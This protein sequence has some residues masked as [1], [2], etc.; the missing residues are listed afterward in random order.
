[1]ATKTG[2]ASANALTGTTDADVLNGMG[3][4]DTLKGL[5]GNDSLNGGTGN[6]LLDAGT[7]TDTVDGGAGVDTVTFATWS[8]GV[9]LNLSGTYSQYIGQTG[10]VYNYITL[11]NVEN[12]IGGTGA[13][14]LYGSEGA[15]RME[16]RNGNDSILGYGGNDSLYGGAGNDS[17]QGGDG[18]D[19]LYGDAGADTLNGGYGNDQAFG[20]DGDD[21]FVAS[22][23]AD[24]FNGGAGS[25]TISLE[26][27]YEVN[28]SLATGT[29]TFY[30]SDTLRFTGVENL[31]GGWSDDTLTGSTGANVLD[32]AQGNDSLNG[33]AGNDT[34]VGGDGNDTLVGGTGIDT[35][36][37]EAATVGVTVNLGTTA[38]QNTQV[39]T[40][41]L[42]GI[43]NVT[44]S[45][46]NDV[47]TGNAG[48]NLFI[49]GEGN[50]TFNG[51]SG[52]DTVSYVRAGT[53]V[54]VDLAKTTA[55]NTLGEGTDKLASIENLVGSGYDD[56][57]AGN[58][59]ANRLTGGLG[60][61]VL[62]GRGG[63]DTL[64]GGAG[65]DTASYTE[66]TTALN[67]SLASATP[68]AAGSAG[69]DTLISI[70]GLAGGSASDRLTGSAG[71]NRLEG[72]A[73]NDTLLGGD[74][75]DTLEGGAGNDALNGGAGV[76][77]ADYSSATTAVTVDLAK[78]AAQN[79]G[80]AG[81]DTLT[82]IERVIG[83]R[84]GDTLSGRSGS[85][86][87]SGGDG[88][89]KLY[90]RGGSDVLIGG[91][92][93]DVLDAGGG[94]GE[95]MIG[96]AGNDRYF[97]GTGAGSGTVEDSLGSHDVIDAS[98]STTAAQID[99][100]TGKTSTSGG[101]SLTLQV[102]G[103]STLPLD[104]VFVQD[105]SGSFGDDIATVRGLVPNVV[106]AIRGVNG[107][108]AFGV[109]GFVDKPVSP[110][111]GY[112]D[113]VY[114]LF[115]PVSMTTSSVSNAYDSMVI[116]SGSDGPESQLE[117]LF[118]VAK[119]ADGEV[120]FRSDTM[121]VAVLFTDADY[122]VAGDGA[123]AYPD[124]ITRP[125]DGDA[126]IE[127]DGTLE[128]YPSIA[129][130]KGAL[131]AAGIFPFFVVDSYQVDNYKDL[132][133]QLGVGGVTTLADSST[134]VVTAIKNATKLATQTQIEDAV[135]SAF[136]DTI[137][138]SGLANDLSGGGGNDT[139][140][141]FAGDDVLTGGTGADVLS[142][143]TGKDAFVFNARLGSGVDTIT[144]FSRADDI[145][146]LEN[147]VFTKLATAGNLAAGNF[148]ANAAGKAMDANDFIV[149]ETDTGKLFYDADGSGAGAAV[150]IALIGTGSTHPA[151]SAAD[152]VVI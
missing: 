76:D 131:L 151:L 18:A 24:T 113:Y 53:R 132:V 135:G 16:G 43:E 108:S 130:L 32:G 68:Q 58:G 103:S 81:S 57:L 109:V 145:I 64:D 22:S 5:A 26:G 73:G 96:G 29:A 3:G 14:T 95:R 124:P 44:G 75:D 19:V 150:Q 125:N 107:D 23:G 10:D 72:N 56:M 48:A 143:G 46:F 45:A 82:S 4:N 121:R 49:G 117:A 122:H 20:G 87:L 40:D 92:G 21:V 134:N 133:A 28:M 110:F 147:A 59:S 149:Y 25:D 55:Q 101:H 2:N 111:G 11:L 78:T 37:Y 7:G 90:G 27:F 63:N 89:D 118:Q 34:L 115:S 12:V 102:G 99:L 35:A 41:K 65:F 70:E 38:A 93:D 98:K 119:R 137:K 62:Q 116:Q 86:T 88:N 30:G 47:L 79:T 106:N 85:D 33:G 6:D 69:S 146:R 39:G 80:G 104:V 61:D 50:D 74:G 138:G 140:S 67:L 31:R 112:D 142:G 141:G 100:T 91:D 94:T 71:A 114:R 139:L 77:T 1:M 129:Q 36:S 127:G 60:D 17:V 128:D 9:N 13:D 105:L 123:S 42:S 66:V 84:A 15:N 51:G 144:D 54:S 152:F 136:A 126:V 52:S 97:L 148:V 8:T 120:G 83:G